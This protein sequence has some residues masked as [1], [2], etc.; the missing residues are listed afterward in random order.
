MVRSQKESLNIIR[1]KTPA[2]IIAGSGM[3][4]GGRVLRHLEKR[5]PES[6]N[7]VLLVGYQAPGTR[8]RLLQSG[9]QELKMF[10]KYIPVKARIEN[11]STLSAHADQ[12]ETLQWLKNFKN[13][14]EKV[15]L[16]HGEPQSS[17][18]LRV[19]IKDTFG[20]QCVIPK[21]NESFTLF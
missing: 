12:K 11:L 19:K 4:T 21:I 15:F 8:G 20:W 18:A 16:V 7:T 10:G 17:D 13:K 9:I 3:L 1:K 14:P 5:L 6:N 2:I